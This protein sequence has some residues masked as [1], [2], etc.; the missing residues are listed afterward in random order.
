MMNVSFPRR[1]FTLSLACGLIALPNALFAISRAEVDRFGGLYGPDET[2]TVKLRMT[3]AGNGLRNIGYMIVDMNGKNVARNIMPTDGILRVDRQSVGGRFGAYRLF[4]HRIEA[5]GSQGDMLCGTSVAFLSSKTVKPC[6]WMGT[7]THASHGWGRGDLRFVDV[8]AQI[9]LGVVR[10]EIGWKNCEKKKGVYEVDACFDR[11]VDALNARGI[12]LDFLL[13]YE[14]GLYENPADPEAFSRWAVYM[15]R[16]YGK[17]INMFEIWNEPGNF[18]FRRRYGGE[19]YGESPWIRKFVSFT[20]T[21]SEALHRARPDASVLVC[22]EDCW[23]TLEAEFGLGIA[24]SGDVVSIHPYCHGQIRPE[25]EMFFK[26][27]GSLVRDRI[28]A[29][30]GSGRV[31]ITEVGW[32]TYEGKMKFETVMG[33]YPRASLEMQARYLSRMMLMTPQYGADFACQ[34]DLIDDGPRREFTEHNFGILFEGVTPKPSAA[35]LAW[36]A[37]Y[38]GSAKAAGELSPETDKMR[39]CRFTLPN[40]M[41]VLAAWAVEGSCSCD[42]V[43]PQ[44]HSRIVCR[45]MFGNVIRVPVDGKVL[46]LDENPVYLEGLD[47][48]GLRALPRIDVV[49]PDDRPVIGEEL[50]VRVRLDERSWNSRAFKPAELDLSI[51]TADGASIRRSVPFVPVRPATIYT[52]NVY[53]KKGVPYAPVRFSCSSKAITSC[54]AIVSAPF[55]S[56]PVRMDFPL[57]RNDLVCREVVLDRP[58]LE[59]GEEIRVDATYS[60][61]YRITDRRIVSYATIH[62]LSEDFVVA[63]RWSDWE[64]SAKMSATPLFVSFGGKRRVDDDDLSVDARAGW[65]GKGLYVAVKVRDDVFFQPYSNQGDPEDGDAVG[66]GIA[67]NETPRREEVLLARFPDGAAVIEKSTFGESKE[68]YACKITPLSEGELLYELFMPWS[69]C[70]RVLDQKAA[71]LSVFVYDND[72]NGLKGGFEIHTGVGRHRDQNRLLY[73][74][75]TLD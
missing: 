66:I 16:R 34:Y 22:A 17:K 30:G 61:G 11:F 28:R 59:Q 40:G 44:E 68:P 7:V 52:P 64:K 51:V 24:G 32:T 33:G 62:R 67:S 47:L 6:P 38:L 48:S 35:A 4:F 58:P 27:C 50:V 25:R 43:V 45:D 18:F 3:S 71:R 65:N 19:R 55:L 15:A 39:L 56:K 57:K 41:D 75:Y 1:V 31:C 13:S 53:G 49:V 23:P 29:G 36:I 42:L 14:N 70:R 21:V 74:I 73:G 12:A 5:D 63:G 60:N 2:A 26:D 72:G 10:E 9:G 20:K 69:R 37:R 46:L 8:I 54:T